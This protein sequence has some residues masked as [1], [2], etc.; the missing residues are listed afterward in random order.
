LLLY[1][2]CSV[3]KA[4]NGLLVRRFLRETPD[5]VD[6]T[7]S[8]RLTLEALPAVVSPGLPGLVLLPG[9]GAGDQDGFGYAVLRR[10]PAGH[11]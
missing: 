9:A 10:Q 3:L 8:A 6:V 4:E 1:A 2:S 11:Q 5:A 7:E